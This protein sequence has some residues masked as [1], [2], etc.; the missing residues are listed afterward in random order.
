MNAL[1]EVRTRLA[2]LLKDAGFHAFSIVP[3][4]VTPPV[5]MVAPGEPYVTREGATFGG[6]IVRCNVVLTTGRGVNDKTAAEID[7]L[8]LKALDALEAADD[9]VVG[10]V[11]QPGQVALNNQNYLGVSVEVL[12]EI[13]RS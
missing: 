10:D 13:H 8:L 2:D 4:K 12:T 5:A 6:E 1:T 9:F 3:A 11:G 7:E